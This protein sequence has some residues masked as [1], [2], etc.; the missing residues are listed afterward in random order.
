M[1]E[2][3]FDFNLTDSFEKMTPL[4]IA[5]WFG[6]RD[7]VR[8][9]VTLDPDIAHINPYGATALGNA[10]HGSANCPQRAEGDYVETARLLVDAEFPILP[11]RGHLDMGSDE[12][13]V[14]LE[15]RL[16]DT[17]DPQPSG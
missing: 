1:N 12:I 4:H 2:V 11:D 5:A 16:A 9:L 14:F 17:A 3:G 7:Y 10:V 8:F 15:E 13:T 6:H